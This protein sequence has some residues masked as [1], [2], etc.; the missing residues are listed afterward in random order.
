MTKSSF[1]K[2]TFTKRVVASS[3]IAAALLMAAPVA[4][5]AADD[6]TESSGA[7]S[8]SERT[9]DAEP[10]SDAEPASASPADAEAS[11]PGQ[12]DFETSDPETSEPG[13]SDAGTPEPGISDAGTPEP[14]TSEPEAQTETSE[15][16]ETPETDAPSGPSS[17]TW[18]PPATST[19]AVNPHDPATSTDPTSDS[20]SDD[21]TTESS[22]AVKPVSGQPN[23]P[24][25]TL[26]VN[27]DV[28]TD[29]PI[30][31]PGGTAVVAQSVEPDSVFYQL[32]HGGGVEGLI[33]F[34]QGALLGVLNRRS[35]GEGDEYLELIS[36]GDNRFIPMRTVTEG[37]L[38]KHDWN[39]AAD[40]LNLDDATIQSFFDK[41]LVTL[42]TLAEEGV[43]AP[44]ARAM[45]LEVSQAA[46]AFGRSYFG[47]SPADLLAMTPE[48]I[49]DY[50]AWLQ[51]LAN[52]EQAADPDNRFVNYG[53]EDW[54]AVFT[55]H[56]PPAGIT[57]SIPSDDSGS[58]TLH[59]NSGTDIA[60][61]NVFYPTYSDQGLVVIGAG[62][63]HTFARPTQTAPIGLVSYTVQTPRVDGEPTSI[64]QIIVTPS[65]VLGDTVAFWSATESPADYIP[66]AGSTPIDFTGIDPDDRFHDAGDTT[67]PT[68]VVYANPATAGV[69]YSVADDNYVT[70]YNDGTDDIAVTQ[71]AP[72]GQT[73]TFDILAPGQSNTYA[74]IPGSWQFVSVQAPTAADGSFVLLGS[75]YNLP[76]GPTSPS[77][78]EDVPG[79]PLRDAPPIT[80]HAPTGSL[81]ETG[82]SQDGRSI[83][84]RPQA[85]DPDGDT[86]TYSVLVQPFRGTVVHNNDGTFTYTVTDPGYLHWGEVTDL[87]VVGASDGINTPTGLAGQIDIEFTQANNAPEVTVTQAEH[88]NAG[89]GYR[90]YLVD[91]DDADWGQF[92]GWIG[93]DQMHYSTTTPSIGHLSIVRPAEG[94]VEV[95][96]TPDLGRAHE[97]AYDTTFD[98]I[99]DDGHD[100]GTVTIPVTI[101]V[102][103]YN[104][105]PTATITPGTGSNG[106]FVTNGEFMLTLDDPDDDEVQVVSLTATSGAT[107]HLRDN[108]IVYT[109]TG[110]IDRYGYENLFYSEKITVVVDDGHGGVTTETY[111]VVVANTEALTWLEPEQRRTLIFSQ[112]QAEVASKFG[113]LFT[114]SKSIRSAD[115]QALVADLESTFAPELDG[116]SDAFQRHL[117]RN[118]AWSVITDAL[119][120]VARSIARI[121][122]VVQT[123]DDALAAR[124]FNSSISTRVVLS[125]LTTLERNIYGQIVEV[126]EPPQ[127]PPR[128]PTDEPSEVAPAVAPAS[129][130]KLFET[131]W[132]KTSPEK[133]FYVEHVESTADGVTRVIVYVGGTDFWNPAAGQSGIENAWAINSY[134]DRD[135]MLAI[136]DAI[137][138]TAY[139]DS[140]ALKEVLLVG[141]SQGGIDAINMANL[142]AFNVVG[143]VTFGSPLQTAVVDYPAIHIRDTRDEVVNWVS[144]GD[145]EELQRQEGNIFSGRAST[146]KDWWNPSDNIHGDYNTYVEVGKQF[147]NKI[148]NDLRSHDD[149]RRVLQNF[150]GE[151][152]GT[153]SHGVNDWLYTW[154]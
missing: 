62:E 3:G 35:R 134:P 84:F 30:L 83:T 18:T 86:I 93:F 73:L 59:N 22:P 95:R 126:A 57:Y 130:S 55:G 149:I 144:G 148:G 125:F 96:Y 23:L 138:D 145:G 37:S 92:P 66:L 85:S 143:V 109:P 75:V 150:N 38:G 9:E 114:G 4:A 77:V 121:E 108:V 79:I 32:R 101:H 122:S 124:G 120:V 1:K 20:D 69:S 12:D 51:S 68:N 100:G 82:R 31:T 8:S 29:G 90:T 74:K 136:E 16:D 142:D 140:G 131:L 58:F 2:I 41:S 80:N 36:P 33:L 76:D 111:N 88:P 6:S 15:V 81:I 48:E 129:T 52:A 42:P 43:E 72:G 78:S 50:H 45:M 53:D 135:L 49:D 24:A 14:G 40:E 110:S 132:S 19:P 46:D 119:I 151:V 113:G 27:P 13:T 103:F 7:S 104:E 89:I 128:Q 146:T 70:I 133:P 17:P 112:G 118:Y 28:A 71:A 107:V 61:T 106:L 39:S 25:F 141:Y 63:S 5:A 117:V 147:D 11:E 44:V 87:F 60:V 47:L 26:T 123:V 67:P 139:D 91:V 21:G 64:G 56:K 10:T 152:I 154:L 65:D 153:D 94:P 98:I 34:N 137:H 102:P 115:Y 97:S 99:V 127:Y 116:Y 54:G 105:N